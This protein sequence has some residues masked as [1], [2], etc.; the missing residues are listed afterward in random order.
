MLKKLDLIHAMVLQV[1]K[2]KYLGCV[3]FSFKS[4]DSKQLKT[5]QES[6]ATGIREN[7]Q[8]SSKPLETE[9]SK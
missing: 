6:S 7:Q 8:L 5:S 2:I 3:F 1:C 9:F 4:F